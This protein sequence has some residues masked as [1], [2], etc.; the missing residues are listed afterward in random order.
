MRKAPDLREIFDPPDEIVEAGLNGDLVFFIGSGASRL[1][2]LPSWAGLA[3]KA[4]EDLRQCGYLNFSEI[5]QLNSLDPK[6]LLS[7]AYSIAED[8]RYELNLAKH[9]AAKS[10]S[11][12][13]YKAINDI[14]CS[15]V[16]TNYDELLAP[17]FAATKDGSTTAASLHRVC[18]K[19]KFYAKLLN[20]PGTVVHLHG[21]ISE[22]RSMIVTTKDYLEHYDHEKV[23]EFLGELFEKKTILFLGYGLDEAEVLEHILRRGSVKSTKDRRRFAL[24]GFFLSQKPLYENLHTYYEKSFGVHLL[25]FVRDHENY[26]CLEAIIKTW[27]NKIEVRKPP[28]AVDYDF[29]NEVLN[30]E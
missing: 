19:E 28:L 7:I 13:I 5:E 30:N 27:A 21:A 17:R 16:T 9:L 10:E 3:E 23:Q 14:G 25:G 12:S 4:I 15:C 26:K 2:G 24:Q 1:L 22:P 20:E 6:K 8:N 11:D 29:L 18:D